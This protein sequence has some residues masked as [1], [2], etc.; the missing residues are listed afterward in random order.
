M[1]K[2]TFLL[3]L[4]IAC[5]GY[6]QKFSRIDF[7]SIKHVLDADTA[8]YPRLGERLKK[9]DSTLTAAEYRL[10]YYGQVYQRT[11]NPYGSGEVRDKFTEQYNAGNYQQAL[12]YG[13]QVIQY[14]PLDLSSLYRLAMCYKSSGN[15]LMKKR[16]LRTFAALLDCIEQSG[17]GLSC[18]TAFVTAAVSDEYVVL[19]DFDLEYQGQT[20]SGKCDMFKVEKNEKFQGKK[21]YFNAYWPLKKMEDLLNTK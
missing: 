7:D 18:E 3:S 8:F 5:S 2:I 20:L 19:G 21:I 13:E 9:F 10:L 14:S 1:R 15:L 12:P 11:Y 16:A 6:A 17:D 4:L